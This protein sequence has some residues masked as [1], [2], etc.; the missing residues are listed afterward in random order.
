MPIETETGTKLT[1]AD[2]V[3][4]PEDGRRHEII[5]GT[6]IVNP[7]PRPVHQSVVLRTSHE[8]FRLETKGWAKVYIAPIDVQLTDHDV[9]QPDV[10][11]IARQNAGI[12]GDAKIEGVPDLVVEVLSPSTRRVDRGSKRALYEAAGVLEYWIIDPER[13][14]LERLTHVD[15]RFV[16]ELFASGPVA[17]TAFLGFEFELDPI[18]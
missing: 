6:H 11:V 12:I 18:F 14:T 15:G 13:R 10:I 2:Y 16:T 17:S 8:L 9:V 5:E 1:Y 7:A 3:G 4:I